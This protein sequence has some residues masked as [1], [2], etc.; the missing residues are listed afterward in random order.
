MKETLL[1]F[2]FCLYHCKDTLV[3][4]KWDPTG[5]ILLTCA[6]EENVKLWGPAAGCWRC[7]HSLCHPSIV[8]GIAWCSL[9]GRGSKLQL[10]MATYVIMCVCM[11]VLTFILVQK[12]ICM[13]YGFLVWPVTVLII[14]NTIRSHQINKGWFSSVKFGYVISLSGYNIVRILI[15]STNKCSKYSNSIR[16]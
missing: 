9:P 2:F 6:K 7:L 16:T 11:C 14:C 3:S 10:L 13:K 4:I 12:I 5:H 15:P 8:N 1:W